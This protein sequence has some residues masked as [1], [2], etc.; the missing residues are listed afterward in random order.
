ML[1]LEYN[2]YRGTNNMTTVPGRHRCRSESSEGSAT[3]PIVVSDGGDDG[4]HP[5]DEETQ[6][7]DIPGED[8]EP[9][10]VDSPWTRK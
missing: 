9:D 1:S 7:P 3:Q 5:E 2:P 8:Q 6:L 4:H 10:V